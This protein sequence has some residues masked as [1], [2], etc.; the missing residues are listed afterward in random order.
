MT[1]VFSATAPIGPGAVLLSQLG[2]FNFEVGVLA[3]SQSIVP[4]TV[5]G[6]VTASG[7][8]VVVNPSATDGSQNFAGIAMEAR[9]TVA[10]E[11]LAITFLDRGP[12]E[13][14]EQY[15]TFPNGITSPQRAT[16]RT[17]ILAANIKLR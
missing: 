1:Q 12:A 2:S 7:Q 15:L 11:T 14:A 6:R 9:T 8:L 16:L 13:V 3:A 4:G 17:A 5:L 10:G